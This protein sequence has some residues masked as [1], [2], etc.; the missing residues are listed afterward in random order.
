MVESRFE[1]RSAHIVEKYIPF[2]RACFGD[3]LGDIFAFIVDDFVE[4]CLLLE[5]ITLAASPGD[6]HDAAPFDAGDLASN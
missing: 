1:D 2:L 6:S 5:P 3:P 4:A